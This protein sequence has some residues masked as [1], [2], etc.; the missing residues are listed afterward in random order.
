MI[1]ENL[2]SCIA[3]IM[4]LVSTQVQPGSTA[5]VKSRTALYRSILAEFNTNDTHRTS[6]YVWGR[7]VLFAFFRPRQNIQQWA[8]CNP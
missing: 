8:I 1:I 6:F 2:C 4:D 7:K 5:I 3:I